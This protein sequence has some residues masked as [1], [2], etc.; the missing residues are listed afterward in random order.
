MGV[1][2]THDVLPQESHR[3]KVTRKDIVLGIAA[4]VPTIVLS[5]LGI[6]YRNEL[7]HVSGIFG[8]SLIGMLLISF[9]AGSLLS[10]TA[11]PV[12][13]WLFVFALPSILAPQW[14]LTAP[15]IVALVSALGATLGH[16]PTFF[17]G[18]GGSSLAEKIFSR[19]DSRFHVRAMGWAKKHG[20]WASFLISAVFNPI[21]LPM[22]IAMGMIRYS[23]FK[24]FIFSFLGNTLKGLFLAFAGYYGIN[25]ILHL[26]GAG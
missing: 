22:T 5:V 21:H 13:Y 9:A 16:M 6:Q 24:F 15:V 20:A 4:T 1:L 19:F 10:F 8:Y 26:I 14:G 12:P 11:V 17:L 23:P 7:L 18:W 2:E 3:L 25:S